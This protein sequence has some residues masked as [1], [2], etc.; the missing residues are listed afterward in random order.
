MFQ[1][2]ITVVLLSLFLIGCSGNT[3]TSTPDEIFDATDG[4]SNHANDP[5]SG[6]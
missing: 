4:T 3:L 6:L 2:L 5:D 1:K